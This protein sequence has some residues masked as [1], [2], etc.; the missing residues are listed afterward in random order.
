MGCLRDLK[1]WLRFYDDKLNR[2]DVARCLAEANLV[3]GDL[4]PILALYGDCSETDKHK[5]RVN[6]ACCAYPRE[7]LEQKRN[8]D[9]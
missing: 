8:I 2:M 7:V 1:K 9:F 3:N 4:V 6:L 5:I